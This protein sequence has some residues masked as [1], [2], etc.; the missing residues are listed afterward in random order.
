MSQNTMNR[1]FHYRS[2]KFNVK[3]ELNTKIEKRM[4]GD[5]FSRITLNDMGGTSYYE[6]KEVNNQ[7]L[8]ESIQKMEN[9]A[10]HFVD[11]REK[12]EFSPLQASL[13]ELGFA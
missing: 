11:I 8:T 2:Y 12:K 9:D 3:V 7:I 4:G 5:S 1:E 6:V 13:L 10:R